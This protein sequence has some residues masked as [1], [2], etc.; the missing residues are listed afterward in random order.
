MSRS[1]HHRAY[2]V[3]LVLLVSACQSVGSPGPAVPEPVPD[4][5]EEP[6]RSSQQTSWEFAGSYVG[7]LVIVDELLD[8]TMEISE[9]DGR[10][11]VLLRTPDADLT[12][13][14]TAQA[15]ANAILA[16]LA[17]GGADCR[18][19]M[20]FDARWVEERSLALRYLL[21]ARLHG[22]DVGPL[23]VPVPVG[24]APNAPTRTRT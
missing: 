8:S 16:D 15:E 23:F 13:E 5:A 14:G 10:L 1:T 7:D 9:G 22:R 11:N 20:T 6:D 12:A 19:A 24:C 17:Y 2:L 21:R 3:G 18:G 4:R